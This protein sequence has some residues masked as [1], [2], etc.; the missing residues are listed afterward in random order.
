MAGCLCSYK[1]EAASFLGG[2]LKIQRYISGVAMIRIIFNSGLYFGG[3]F[4]GSKRLKTS[5]ELRS[6]QLGAIKLKALCQLSRWP[7]MP[8]Q[9]PAGSLAWV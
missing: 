8:S 1:D 9:R 7:F 5:A 2:F 3:L 6:N 4:S